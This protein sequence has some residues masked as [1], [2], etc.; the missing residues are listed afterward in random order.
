MI[1]LSK[2]RVIYMPITK[3]TNALKE[4]TIN[5][6]YYGFIAILKELDNEII[7]GQI[8]NL[9]S[10]FIYYFKQIIG[11]VNNQYLVDN[12]PGT[13][14][15]MLVENTLLNKE[16]ISPTI[17]LCFLLEQKSNLGLDG[18][19]NEI[20]FSN[21]DS[22]NR[23]WIT[24]F[25]DENYSK[26]GINLHHYLNPNKNPDEFN[27][28]IMFD[29]LHEL[30][31]VY[32]LTRVEST[33]NVF[34]KLVYYDYQKDKLLIQNGGNNKSI[35]FHQA[36]LSEFMADEQAYVFM[37]TLAQNHP[38]YFNNELIQAKQI[39][40]KKRK[41]GTYGNYGA[42]PREAF[43]ELIE[44]IRKAYSVYSK[45]STA[46]VNDLLNKIEKLNLKSKPLIE[47]LQSDGISEKA[48]DSY[49]NIYLN[50]FYQFSDDK[51]VYNDELPNKAMS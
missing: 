41:D 29:L 44:D 32:Q 15:H 2:E 50:K 8:Y 21:T 17:A 1:S 38:E 27:Y 7:N 16:K 49:Y 51:I 36:L 5:F 26:I 4:L 43:A 6:S 42:N 45:E 39:E 13:L 33:E 40:Y 48:W 35:L 23:M 3:Y 18:V 10:E 14:G 37:L 22:S 11:M 28:D 9:N 20:S 24:N 25:E 47:Q 46:S 12:K 19:C 31:H 34:D 30:T